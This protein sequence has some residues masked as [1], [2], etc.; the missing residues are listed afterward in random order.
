M[1]STVVITIISLSAIG[2]IA[3]FILY[4]IAQKFKVYEDP[5]IDDVEEAL[6]AANCGGCGYPGCRNFAESCVKADDLSELY[7]PVGGN[8]TMDAVAKILGMDAV[9]QVKKIAVLRCDGACEHRPNTNIY[10]GAENCTVTA[11]LYGGDTGCEYGCLGMGECVEVCDFDALYMDPITGLP[12]V[13]EENCTACNACVE[14]CPK[15]LF[16]L[17]KQGPKGRRIYVSCRNEEKGGI[18]KKSCSVACIGCSK[19]V[20]EC[21]HDA[22]TIDNFL[23]FI[24]DDK[25]K[26]CRKC[27]P[28]CPTQCI[29]ETNFPPRKVKTENKEVAVVK[30]GIAENNTKEKESNT[31]TENKETSDNN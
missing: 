28:V 12:V 19:C 27:V 18:A 3:A 25:C 6:P 1:S 23:A 17:R 26:L 8:D 15:D 2:V 24:H 22:I 10:D 4:F 30:D 11:N 16:E 31:N 13:R 5:R 7:C 20:K 29:T 14:V 9:A 21:P